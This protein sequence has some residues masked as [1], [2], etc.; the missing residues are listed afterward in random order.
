MSI[1]WKKITLEEKALLEPYYKY[2]QSNSCE[3][4]FAN[5][6]LWSPFYEIEFAIVEG[7]LTFLT[8]KEGYS[9][10]MPMANAITLGS[11]SC[12]VDATIKESVSSASPA[13]IAMASP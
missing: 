1:E 5:N 4:A 13:R 6:V 7:M 3:A 8:K 11:A 2:E 12:A 9:A 10:S